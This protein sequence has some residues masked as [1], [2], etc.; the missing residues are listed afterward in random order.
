[1]TSVFFFQQL[2]DPPILPNAVYFDHV[3]YVSVTSKSHYVTH[4][5]ENQSLNAIHSA[6]CDALHNMSTMSNMVL[7]VKHQENIKLLNHA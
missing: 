5:E 3:C 1:M 4:F 7:F 6:G 2:L